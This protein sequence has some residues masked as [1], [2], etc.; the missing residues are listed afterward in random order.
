M[1]GVCELDGDRCDGGIPEE[2][3][4]VVEKAVGFVKED[5]QWIRERTYRRML[6]EWGDSEWLSGGVLVE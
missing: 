4:W 2:R 1:D 3:V 6:P 5:S